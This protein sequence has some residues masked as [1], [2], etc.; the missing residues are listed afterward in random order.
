MERKQWL[1]KFMRLIKTGATMLDYRREL[2]LFPK[3]VKGHLAKL[4]KYKD[5]LKAINAEEVK[6][7][8]VRDRLARARAEKEKKRLEALAKKVEEDARQSDV[9]AG[10]RW[11]D[12]GGGGTRPDVGA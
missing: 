6:Q 11:E 1:E 10:D 8:S 4:Q 2:R 3:Q 12:D 5:E 9:G 7:R